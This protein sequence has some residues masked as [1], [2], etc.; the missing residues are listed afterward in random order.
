MQTTGDSA[1]PSSF[2]M[3]NDGVTELGELDKAHPDLGA[4]AGYDP[5]LKKVKPFAL[6]EAGKPSKWIALTALRILK[7]VEDAT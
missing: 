7:R 5:K 1:P 6:V 3:T 2:S 4:G